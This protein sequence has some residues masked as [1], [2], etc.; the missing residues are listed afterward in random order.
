MGKV[1]GFDPENG[2]P[3]ISIDDWY[4]MRQIKESVRYMQ[5]KDPTAYERAIRKEN[6]LYKYTLREVARV[7]A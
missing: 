6:Q 5:E 3:R 4:L 2:K 7:A 1:I